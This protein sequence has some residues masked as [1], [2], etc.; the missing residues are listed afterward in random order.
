[1][2]I[3]GI[4]SILTLV[5]YAGALIYFLGSIIAA[6]RVLGKSK[7]NCIGP[8]DLPPESRNKGQYLLHLSEKYLQYTIE[9]YKLNN[10]QLSIV[11]F[12]QECFRNA[13]ILLITCGLLIGLSGV[14][15]NE[16]GN[17]EDLRKVT[18]IKC[19]IDCQKQSTLEPCRCS[20][21]DKPDRN[22]EVLEV[23]GRTSISKG[24]IRPAKK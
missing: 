22:P 8:D 5:A 14:W 3:D 11:Y 21:Q 6:L 24:A 15:G 12:S 23:P 9:N 16:S 10:I 4:T 7:R 18:E 17:K 20:S 19:Y 13:V 1:L 2:R